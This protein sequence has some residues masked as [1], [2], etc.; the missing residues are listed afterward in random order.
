MVYTMPAYGG[1]S[2]S[3]GCAAP[4]HIERCASA[5]RRFLACQP[6]I[7][8]CH[9]VE[10][11]EP[12]QCQRLWAPRRGGLAEEAGVIVTG[13]YPVQPA[14]ERNMNSLRR[15]QLRERLFRISV[16]LKGLNGA[17]E[18]LGG[19]ALF[20]VSPA[21]ILRTVALLT[22]DEIAEDPRDLV[23]N[24]L[25]RA[26]SHLSPAS[27]H[28]AAIYLL[29]HG[30]IKVGLVGALLK[31][32]IWAYPAAV[33]VFGAFIIYQLYRFALTHG[34]GLIALSLFDLVV[35]WLIY[36]EYRALKRGAA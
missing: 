22:Q 2:H 24:S 33:I 6:A 35:I 27:E 7:Q 10:R 16:L 34:L 9:L 31:H 17:L 13:E 19:V 15:Q 8:R 18:I 11:P 14:L 4:R 28:F 20:A 5:E 3:V 29:I 25:R 26:A 23:A 12:A 21:F 1:C 36:L 30:V 32:E